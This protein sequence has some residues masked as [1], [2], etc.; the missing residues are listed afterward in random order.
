MLYILKSRTTYGNP[1]VH[2]MD[3]ASPS[4][5]GPDLPEASQRGAFARDQFHKYGRWVATYLPGRD[6]TP[7]WCRHDQHWGRL[8][9]DLFEQ[10]PWEQPI[11]LGAELEIQ[12]NRTLSGRL[13]RPEYCFT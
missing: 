4:F 3:S 10:L 1:I 7:A 5:P 2:V 12:L 9:V 8:W 13:Q 6:G 11:Q